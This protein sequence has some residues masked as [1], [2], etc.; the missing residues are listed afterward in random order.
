MYP[1]YYPSIFSRGLSFLKTIKWGEFLDGTQ[2][3]L[4]VIHQAIPIAYQV[5]PMMQNAKTIFKIANVMKEPTS[6]LETK[7]EET[8]VSSNQPIFYL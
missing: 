2:K 8:K 6:T 3:T 7:K 4:G 5:K 1:N